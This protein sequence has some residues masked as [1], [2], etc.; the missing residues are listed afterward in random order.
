MQRAHVLK[1]IQRGLGLLV[2]VM[3]VLLFIQRGADA[4]P[5]TIATLAGGPVT[6]PMYT[7]D[8][9]VGN[10]EVPIPLN[11][12]PS[13][14]FTQKA[15]E[16]IIVAAE[17]RLTPSEGTSFCGARL[18]VRG[19]ENQAVFPN[20]SAWVGLEMSQ[21]TNKGDYG[22]LTDSEI[23]P[24]PATDRQISIEAVVVEGERND[25]HLEAF[26]GPGDTCDGFGPGSDPENS[27]HDPGQDEWTARVRVS[28]ASLR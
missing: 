14:T 26:Y 2:A 24:A 11:G 20:S 3:L 28:I 8:E 12:S 1:P 6:T 9:D 22:L 18:F 27:D 23:I 21:H 19:V 16:V 25:P 15:S 10:V 13:Y 17:A 5:K 4:G 7:D